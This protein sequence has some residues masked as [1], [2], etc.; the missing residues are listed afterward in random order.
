MNDSNFQ[1]NAKWLCWRQV[2]MKL[3]KWTRASGK[4]DLAFAFSFSFLI[5]NYSRLSPSFSLS[6][7][8]V[9]GVGGWTFRAR[10]EEELFELVKKLGHFAFK[11][12][13]L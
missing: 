4:A 6:L 10:V 2:R 7:P 1:K 8:E 12:G 9:G 5:H 3:S 11:R 13:F